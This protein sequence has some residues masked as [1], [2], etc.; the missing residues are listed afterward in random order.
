MQSCS[1]APWHIC[2]FPIPN[3]FHNHRYLCPRLYHRNL[4]SWP[5]KHQ[6]HLTKICALTLH[7]TNSCRKE[8]E[9]KRNKSN[10]QPSHTPSQTNIFLHELYSSTENFNQSK[11]TQDPEERKI[12]SSRVIFTNMWWADLKAALGQRFNFEGIICSA[13]VLAK[14]R[15]LAL[16]HVAVPDIRYIDWAELHRR[17][18]KG[19]VF[20]KDNTLTKPYSLTLWE[21]IG[22]S[23]QQCKSVFGHDIG[24]FSNSAG[25]YEYDPDGSK[26]RVLEG[27][28]GIEVIRHR[29]KKPAGTAE[30]IEK[31]FGCA[32]SLLIMVGDR[33]FTDIVFGNRNGFLTILTEPLSLA[34][35]PFLVKQVRKLEAFVVN[36]CYKRGLKP[37]NHS[38]LP[39]AQ[40]CVKNPPPL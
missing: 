8:Q 36:R 20:D 14:D 19:V 37:T 5:C 18:F 11:T 3:Q 30:E 9:I 38:L 29:V 24:V 28:I 21:P 39:D 31:H 27:A 6:T 26:A 17:G 15:H 23:L 1:C 22:S 12:N 2:K 35:E 32:S 34:E 16:P 40:E 4:P 25:L 33:P 7:P 13:V 10:S